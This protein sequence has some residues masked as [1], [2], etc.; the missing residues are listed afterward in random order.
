MKATKLLLRK[1]KI[2]EG[3]TIPLA[4]RIWGLEP[5]YDVTKQHL[6]N[7][8]HIIKAKALS[9]IGSLEK[10]KPKPKVLR[11]A[12]GRRARHQT[13]QY[14][15][16]L[17]RVELGKKPYKPKVAPKDPGSVYSIEGR[18]RWREVGHIPYDIERRR[19]SELD[20]KDRERREKKWGEYR[21]N[22]LKSQEPK[23]QG[24]VTKGIRK[25][26]GVLRAPTPHPIETGRDIARGF[27][28]IAHLGKMYKR[29]PKLM[30]KI[31]FKKKE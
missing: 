16:S 8:G 6:A 29:H 3:M 30:H 1:D 27:K 18:K 10:K 12:A 13:A 28:D 19:R 20:Q 2:E 11:G 7:V 5:A 25:I 26:R 9:A 24:K 31:L 23:K 15:R 14:Q 22:W 21:K 4:M 17:R